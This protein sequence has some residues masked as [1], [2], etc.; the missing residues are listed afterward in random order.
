MCPAVPELREPIKAAVDEFIEQHKA[1]VPLLAMK[2]ESDLT[3]WEG[4]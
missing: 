4:K 3:S 2:W 1:T